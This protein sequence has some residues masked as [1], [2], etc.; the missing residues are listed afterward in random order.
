MARV[1][2][3]DPNV[4]DASFWPGRRVFVTGATGMIGSQLVA[5]LLAA[6]ADVSVL[7]RD[8]DPRSQ[9]YRSGNVA[10]VSLYSGA[11]EHLETLERAI[12]ESEASVVFHCA[13]Q[14]L[15][16]VGQ[17]APLLTFESNVRGTYNLL[18]ACRRQAPFI[19]AVVLASS[20]KAYGTSAKL[21]YTED[22]PLRGEA[23][24]E[25]SKSAADL[26]ARSYFLTYALPLA[27][28][29]CGN[30]YGAGDLNWS[31]IV[32]GTIRAY[33]LGSA[34]EIRSDGTYRRD[35]I[36][37]RDVARAYLVVAQALQR[38]EIRGEAFNFASGSPLTVLELVKH[39]ADLIGGELPAPRIL[40]T[41][42]NE[43]VDQSLSTKK[44]QTMLNWR[45]RFT[46]KDGLEETIAWYR[47]YLASAR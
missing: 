22:L 37:L 45:P 23:P 34:P 15:V 26:I 24:Y 36:Y 42:R 12:V 5:E 28:V 13:A 21:P 41:A 44:A 39:I 8:Q 33:L 11:V 47:D 2:T 35:Y 3:S 40:N 19:S 43:I 38:S 20:D 31:R 6:G 25:V 18:E 46:L 4:G 29:R 32:P 10:R 27:I 16:G 1:V 7:V 30:T 14:T 9:L 17:R